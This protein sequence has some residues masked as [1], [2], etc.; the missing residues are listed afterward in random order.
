MS[1]VLL[2]IV[3]G[4]EVLVQIVSVGYQIQILNYSSDRLSWLSNP[5]SEL[6][7]RSFLKIVL[8][9]ISDLKDR[10][11]PF[12]LSNIFGF[13]L[14]ISLFGCQK[15]VFFVM[16]LKQLCHK[17]A[18]ALTRQFR[19]FLEKCTCQDFN[20]FCPS[21]LFTI[22]GFCLHISPFGCQKSHFI[23]MKLKQVIG[24]CHKL[25]SVVQIPQFCSSDS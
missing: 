3:S 18:S 1:R 9:K 10:F 15:S 14:H 6:Q 5:D 2:Q 21:L 13:C 25:A 17:L 24:L 19:N 16:K 8:V 20:R 12:L 23:V 4:L 22:F 7:F 11:Y